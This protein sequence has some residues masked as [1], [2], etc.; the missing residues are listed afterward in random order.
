MLL[1][2]ARQIKA[3]MLQEPFADKIERDEEPTN[4]TITIKKRMNGLKLIVA[5]GNANQLGHMNR[6]IM[7]E[8]LKV[9]HEVG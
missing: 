7:P 6:V 5:D 3:R 1:Q 4:S 2:M 8:Q 9:S